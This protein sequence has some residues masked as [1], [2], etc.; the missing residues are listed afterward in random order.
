MHELTGV[1]PESRAD[2]KKLIEGA[3]FG[4]VFT[5]IEMKPTVLF[6]GTNG[7]RGSYDPETHTLSVNSRDVG[8]AEQEALGDT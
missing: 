5:P 7:G 8:M 2:C 1:T 4:E 3:V 6:P